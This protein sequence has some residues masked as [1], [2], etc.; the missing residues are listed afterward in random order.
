MMVVHAGEDGD[1]AA[2]RA[3]GGGLHA[4]RQGVSPILTYI[5]KSNVSVFIQ[6][7]YSSSCLYTEEAQLK[8][9]FGSG[10]KQIL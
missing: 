8:A 4:K 3:T 5:L 6:I 7:M 9:Q 10:F 2:G 1:E